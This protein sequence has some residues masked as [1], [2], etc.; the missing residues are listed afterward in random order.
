M[1]R[2]DVNAVLAAVAGTSI[3]CYALIRPASPYYAPITDALPIIASL[4]AII[5]CI[6]SYKDIAFSKNIRHSLGCFIIGLS[7]WC[8]AE[9]I[10]FIFENILKI[11]LPFPSFADALWLSGYPF[12]MAGTIFGLLAFRGLI[13]LNTAYITGTIAIGLFA[14]FSWLLFIPIIKSSSI[15]I[16]EKS[17]DIAY[18]ALDFI[19]LFTTVAILST[20]FKGLYTKPWFLLSAGLAMF[21]LSDISFSYL[22][23][24]GHYRV[25]RVSSILTD[26]GWIIGYLL[27][28]KGFYEMQA[29]ASEKRKRH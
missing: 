29:V 9:T 17:L 19:L 18:P 7:L 4:L 3:L 14:I 8:A 12:L 28:A 23:W 27:L 13:N 16:I 10:W 6:R 26:L 1:R 25:Y 22:T 15:G 11:M 21:A 24:T 2:Q 20:I 5:M